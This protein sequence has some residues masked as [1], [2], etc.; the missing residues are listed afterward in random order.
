M[1]SLGLATIACMS[2]GT[3][4][5]VNLR[6]SRKSSTQSFPL[7]QHS[8]SRVRPVMADSKWL[9]QQRSGLDQTSS[10]G[11]SASPCLGPSGRYVGCS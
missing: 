6:V 11:R 4:G 8:Q 10:L 3:A 7:L 1:V 9:I 5:T 2:T